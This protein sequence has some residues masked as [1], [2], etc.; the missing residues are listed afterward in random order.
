MKNVYKI[1]YES[2]SLHI[3]PESDINEYKNSGFY[4]FTA[5]LDA[6][7]KIMPDNFLTKPKGHFIISAEDTDVAFKNLKK[8]FKYIEAAG[9]LVFNEQN[10]LL[11]IFRRGKFDLPKGKKE[12]DEDIP[13]T[14]IREVEE[15]CGVSDLKIIKQ[16]PSTFHIYYHKKHYVLKKTYWYK[17]MAPNQSVSP[18]TE[19]EITAAEWL[20]I[21]K[22]NKF[23]VNTFLTLLELL[24]SEG[25]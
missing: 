8:E 2:A 23:K 19:E 25:L 17:M 22:I 7:E 13:T 21:S 6:S 16:I 5:T 18:Q 12:K 11:I 20:P 24:K 1:F 9:G 3:V 14:A 4:E 10:E 15:E